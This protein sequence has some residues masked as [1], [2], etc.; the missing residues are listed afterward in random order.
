MVGGVVTSFDLGPIS[1]VARKQW[2]G[3]IRG[4]CIGFTIA[5]LVTWSV[6]LAVE[7]DRGTLALNFIMT[8]GVPYWGL[9]VGILIFGWAA[10]YFGS[11]A[12]SLQIDDDSVAFIY[13]SGG[14]DRLRWSDPSVRLVLW[15]WSQSSS[16]LPSWSLY[17]AAIRFRPR[18]QL[19]AEAFAALLSA[20]ERGKALVIIEPASARRYGVA[21]KRIQLGPRPRPGD[22]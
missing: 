11:G 12:R 20:A 21:G 13:P 8:F 2:R 7:I 15:D 9:P 22:E 16:L 10:Y 14:A 5:L 4:V 19:T 1:D 3:S 6:I 18:T 17:E